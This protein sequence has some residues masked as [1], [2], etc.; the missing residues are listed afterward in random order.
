MHKFHP[1][2]VI[3][4]IKT[5]GASVYHFDNDFREYNHESDQYFS[6]GGDRIYITKEK[7]STYNV[8]IISKFSKLMK[9]LIKLKC[10]I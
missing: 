1:N 7:A 4:D 8:D 10:G 5:L 6:I 2:D 9:A 3:S